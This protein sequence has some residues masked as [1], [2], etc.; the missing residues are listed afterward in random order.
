MTRDHRREREMIPI[1]CTDTYHHDTEEFAA[2]GYHLIE[3][4]PLYKWELNGVDHRNPAV[5]AYGNTMHLK[6]PRRIAARGGRTLMLKCPCG[7]RKQPNEMRVIEIARQLLELDET[8][9]FLDIRR[10]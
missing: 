5:M 8:I 1:G 6:N 4:F 9:A 3:Q 10:L 2:L 7:L